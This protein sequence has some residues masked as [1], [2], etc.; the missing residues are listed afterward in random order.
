M[1]IFDLT[2]RLLDS[3]ELTRVNEMGKNVFDQDNRIFSCVV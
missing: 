1:T 3:P 2:P